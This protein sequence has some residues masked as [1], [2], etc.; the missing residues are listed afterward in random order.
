LNHRSDIF[1]RM[2][3]EFGARSGFCSIQIATEA[4]Q[5][6]SVL[7]LITQAKP[8]TSNFPFGMR[9]VLVFRDDTEVRAPW[10]YNWPRV[11]IRDSYFGV[12]RA[13]EKQAIAWYTSEIYQQL[14]GLIVVERQ[15]M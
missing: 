15:K 12:D 1:S 10:N 13:A 3:H 9:R 5:E 8:E 7:A 2:N 11:H 14:P 4:L 6:N